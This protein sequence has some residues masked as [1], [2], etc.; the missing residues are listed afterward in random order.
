MTDISTKLPAAVQAEI[1]EPS[2]LVPLIGTPAVTTLTGPVLQDF[3]LTNKNILWTRVHSRN[4]EL[5][6]QLARAAHY[7]LTV[8]R[9]LISY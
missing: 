7:L 5:P 6:C 9:T 4:R 3:D 2:P 8:H 1:T